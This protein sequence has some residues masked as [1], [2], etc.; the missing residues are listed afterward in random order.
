MFL[1]LPDTGLVVTV[2][3]AGFEKVK[4]TTDK[5]TADLETKQDKE[6]KLNTYCTKEINQ[7]EHHFP[8]N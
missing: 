4:A 2:S 6:V 3:L 7:N 1:R 5:M 8:G